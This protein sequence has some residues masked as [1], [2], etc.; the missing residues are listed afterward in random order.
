MNPPR[1]QQEPVPAVAIEDIGL[2]G[3]GR[4]AITNPQVAER[5]KVAV[6]S[7]RREPTSAPNTNCA[8]CNTTKGCGPLNTKC[9]PNTVS[10]C[11]AKSLRS[12]YL[13]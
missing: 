3:E 4:V 9:N 11:G 13:E 7:R 2:D 6:G 5:L 10:S 1:A 12:E 8:G